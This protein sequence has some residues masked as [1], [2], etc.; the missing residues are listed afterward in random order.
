MD[1]PFESCL[2]KPFTSS[3]FSC[4]RLGGDLSLRVGDLH[5]E[6]LRL[7]DDFNSLSRG[8]SRGNLGSVCSVVHQEKFDV[9]GVVNEEGL[10]AGRHHVSS[11]LVGTKAD[12]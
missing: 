3:Q 9:A 7:G 1:I 2:T 5:T 10:V 12:L 4:S 8:N 6:R 11:L